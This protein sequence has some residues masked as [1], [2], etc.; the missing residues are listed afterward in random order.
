MKSSTIHALAAVSLVG[1]WQ[2]GAAD[3]PSVDERLK[4]LEGLVEGLQKEN[5]ELKK[6]L[7]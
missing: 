4:K 7:G 6:E 3:A 2:A 1:I 5:T